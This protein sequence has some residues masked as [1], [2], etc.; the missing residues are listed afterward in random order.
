MSS[1]VDNKQGIFA[2]LVKDKLS[3]MF[4]HLVFR[5]FA[6]LC[7]Q[8][9]FVYME[10]VLFLEYSPQF[11]DLGSV[12]IKNTIEMVAAYFII[13]VEVIRPFLFPGY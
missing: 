10:V 1:I 8:T 2:I 6:F 13:R 12:S 3:K 4:V 7:V 9:L 11:I 5:R